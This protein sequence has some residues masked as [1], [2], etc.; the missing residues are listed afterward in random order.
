[1]AKIERAGVEKKP[2]SLQPNVHTPLIREV[3]NDY[4]LK[5]LES[6]LLRAGGIVRSIVTHENGDSIDIYTVVSKPIR[7]LSLAMKQKLGE[8]GTEASRKF[9]P[10]VPSAFYVVTERR[11]AQMEKAWHKGSYSEHIGSP[12]NTLQPSNS[13]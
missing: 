8:I 2:E 13:L 11:L 9:Y 3:L 5:L 12:S 4:S 7:G 1:M 6:G 10:N